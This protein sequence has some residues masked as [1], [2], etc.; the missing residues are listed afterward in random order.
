MFQ[1]NH[2]EITDIFDILS[3]DV[4]DNKCGDVMGAAALLLVDAIRSGSNASEEDLDEGQM[5]AIASKAV[6]E[7]LRSFEL[8]E[9]TVN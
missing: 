3:T 6:C 8:Q 4:K 1:N 9:K 5:E 2:R 7:V